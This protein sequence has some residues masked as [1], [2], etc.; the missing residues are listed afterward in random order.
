[1]RWRALLECLPPLLRR[2]AGRP[3]PTAVVVSSTC[4]DAT[5]NARSGSYDLV[6][7]DTEGLANGSKLGGP[8]VYVYDYAG[9][10]KSSAAVVSAN[11]LYVSA[12]RPM[13]KTLCSA[14]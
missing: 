8:G 13:T 10:G 6:V 14:L 12:P 2:G 4:A 7:I 1:M 9:D 11:G 3:A 5:Q